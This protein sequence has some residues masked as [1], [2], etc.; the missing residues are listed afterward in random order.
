[1]R[2]SRWAA[3]AFWLLWVFLAYKA[4]TGW[5]HPP[6]E[7]SLLGTWSHAGREIGCR[8]D[9]S[10]ISGTRSPLVTWQGSRLI[11]N[12]RELTAAVRDYTPDTTAWDVALARQC[13]LILTS[14]DDFIDRPHVNHKQVGA[15]IEATVKWDGKDQW[16][17]DGVCYT[18]VE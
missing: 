1:M 17:L 9:G 8:A 5:M 16:N 15:N 14:T 3:S 2:P 11:F 7:K 6:P 12:E 10:V 18:R 13:G 4:A